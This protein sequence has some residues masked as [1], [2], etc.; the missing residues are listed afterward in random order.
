M[1]RPGDVFA[2]FQ[3]LSELG[4]GAFGRVFLAKQPDLAHRPVVLKVS[5]HFLGEW[6]ALAQLQHTNIVPI[7]SVHQEAALRA[8]CM[9]YFGAT[10]LHD[11]VAELYRSGGIP[12]SGKEIVKIVSTR[13]RQNEPTVLMARSQIASQASTVAGA[14]QEADSTQ[15]VRSA[16]ASQSVEI[17]VRL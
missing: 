6:E 5:A 9:P 12:Q 4:S 8:I 15:P 10:T 17:L 2:R 13:Q 7:Y 3:L 14:E 11:I 1:P 16:P